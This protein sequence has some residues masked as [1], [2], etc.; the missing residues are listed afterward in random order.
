MIHLVCFARLCVFSLID[1]QVATLLICRYRQFSNPAGPP[2][3]EFQFTKGQKKISYCLCY[4]P[5][6]KDKSD[7]VHRSPSIN[8]KIDVFYSLIVYLVGSLILFGMRIGSL[9]YYSV[10]RW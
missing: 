5:S 2:I 10:H 3:I 8:D 9:I 6:T 7:T 1:S 4:K